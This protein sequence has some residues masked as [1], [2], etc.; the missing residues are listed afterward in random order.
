MNM[1]VTRL[2]ALLALACALLFPVH[3]G[4]TQSF[5]VAPFQINGP[6]QYQ[7]LG[8]GIQDMMISRL[9]WAGNFEAQSKDKI[10]SLTK[11]KPVSDGDAQSVMSQLGVDFLVYGSVTILGQE[12]SVD[13]RVQSAAGKTF[14]QTAQTQLDTLIPTLEVLAGKVNAEIFQRPGKDETA[15]A[16]PKQIN[17]MNPDLVHNETSQGQEF[18]LNPQFRYAGDAESTG[19]TRSRSL[20]YV[21]TS[22]VVGDADA[23]GRSEAF[24]AADDGVYAYR[25]TADNDMKELDRYNIGPLLEIL[26]MSMIDLNR[27]GKAEIIACAMYKPVEMDVQKINNLATLN[28]PRTFIF[29]LVGD[30]LQVVEDD[31]AIFMATVQTPPDYMPKLVGQL[32]GSPK[33]FE[34]YVHE[35]VKMGGKY[36]LGP[37]L[38]LPPEA[39]TFNFT[40]MPMGEGDYKIIIIDDKD[41]LRIYSRTGD[42]Q[43]TSDVQ[44]SGSSLGIVDARN[45]IGLKDQIIMTQPYYVPMRML[46]V[47]LDRNNQFE[48][49]VNRPISVA[50]QFFTRY[51]YYPQGEIHC[52]YWDGMGMSLV[53]KTRRIKGSVADYGLG[54][55]NNDGILDLYVLVNTHPGM[56]GAGSRRTAVLMYPLDT[57]K[58]NEKG[59]PIDREF[60]EEQ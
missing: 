8:K 10:L 5:A 7:Y 32:K 57:S 17:A 15:E 45:R 23:D 60:T 42:R 50:A 29:N 14:P 4:A 18:Y 40:Y 49:L 52:L 19:R 20:P 36:A 39:N 6:D 55:I 58:I 43:W 33:V 2:L 31:I 34:S 25:F 48:M 26:R 54:D 28:N 44:F 11:G 9:H 13:L 53:W 35:I 56:L 41:R 3:A 27:D 37:R 38:M 59:V 46:P 21:S 16:Q 47:N 51:R 12:T 30:K 24:I 1:R 22:I